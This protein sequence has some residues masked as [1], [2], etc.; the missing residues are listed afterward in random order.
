MKSTGIID[1]IE[2]SVCAEDINL[3]IPMTSMKLYVTAD[4]YIAFFDLIRKI[5][6]NTVTKPDL[7]ILS[8]TNF[9]TPNYDQNGMFIPNFVSLDDMS[10]IIKNAIIKISSDNNCANCLYLLIKN[11]TNLSRL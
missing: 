1:L 7:D 2:L 10:S 9:N 3:E 4:N 8:T 6:N 5:C 11:P